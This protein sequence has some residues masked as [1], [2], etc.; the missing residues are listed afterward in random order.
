MVI[1]FLFLASMVGC[2]GRVTFEANGYYPDSNGDKSIGDPRKP[3]FEGSGYS[4]DEG[5]TNQSSDYSKHFDR[6]ND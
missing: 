1:I 2:Q 3:M 6:A 5:Q 4:E